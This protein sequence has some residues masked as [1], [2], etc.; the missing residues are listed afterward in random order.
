MRLPTRRT[1]RSRLVR[2]QP[3]D[4]G[5]HSSVSAGEQAY[6]PK[7]S[8]KGPHLSGRHNPSARGKRTAAYPT[9]ITATNLIRENFIFRAACNAEAPAMVGQRINPKLMQGDHQFQPIEFLETVERTQSA[10]A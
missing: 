1:T 7:C 10:D 5:F 4:D 6:P 3:R 2:Q 9:R 8:V